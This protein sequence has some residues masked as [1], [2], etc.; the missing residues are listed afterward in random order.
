MASWIKHND[1]IINLSN[2]FFYE[3][4]TFERRLDGGKTKTVYSIQFDSIGNNYT[5][6]EFDSEEEREG[7][8]SKLGV[9]TGPETLI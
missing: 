6:L 8:M 1:V 4:K 5:S 2:V 7:C 9:K 3:K